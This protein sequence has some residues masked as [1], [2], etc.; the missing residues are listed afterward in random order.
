MTV[1]SYLHAILSS[2]GAFQQTFHRHSFV[3]T[4]QL[5]QLRGM[6]HRAHES[7][8]QSQEHERQAALLAFEQ[9][10]A[11]QQQ[12]LQAEHQAALQVMQTERCWSPR[13]MLYHMCI[14]TCTSG[15]MAMCCCQVLSL[16]LIVRED[17]RKLCPVPE[18]VCCC[19]VLKIAE[20]WHFGQ[21][22][23]QELQQQQS[24]S[25]ATAHL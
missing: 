25:C 5:C 20:L 16:H 12:V 2:S 24:C 9:E 7:G 8:A 18:A 19:Q 11:R 15:I 4:V 13:H 22:M 23:Q 21:F 6:L 10:R 1:K 3:F 14:V 17:A